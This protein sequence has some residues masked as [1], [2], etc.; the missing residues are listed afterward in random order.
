MK[1][2]ERDIEVHSFEEMETQP[3]IETSQLDDQPLIAKVVE[4]MKAFRNDM[5]QILS[6]KN[7]INSFWLRKT[8][9]PVLAVL[10]VETKDG[11]VH[12]YRGTNMEVSM[13]TGSLC[14]E[15]NVIGTALARNPALRR[16]DLKMIAVLAVPNPDVDSK[17]KVSRTI[18]RPISTVSLTSQQQQYTPSNSNNN[19]ASDSIVNPPSFLVPT[20]MKEHPRPPLIPSSRKSS[21]G[22][23]DDW[24]QQ[25]IAPSSMPRVPI[26][27]STP[28]I[29]PIPSSAANLPST[30]ALDAQG[31]VGGSGGGGSHSGPPTP[32]RRYSLYDKMS[33]ST[34][35]AALKSSSSKQRATVIVRSD[36]DM[37]PLAPCGACNEWLK[38]IAECNPYFTILTFTDSNCHGVFCQPCQE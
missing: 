25:D 37:N 1:V 11:D 18:S 22:N 29:G 4:E 35:A 31:S 3:A 17:G 14:A 24:I 23:E 16:Q 10:A 9:K 6:S 19:I 34:S 2:V 8:H 33:V 20:D 27:L 28:P 7:D 13:P 36:D 30:F 32:G 5:V 38:K 26:V 12:L 21:V 15:R